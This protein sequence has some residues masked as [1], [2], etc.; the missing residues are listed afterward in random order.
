[1]PTT[2][3]TVIDIFTQINAIPRCSKKEAQIARWLGAWADQHG[4]TSDSDAAGNLVIR[5]PA[6]PGFE[7]APVV[8]LQGHMDMV[9]EKTPESDHDFDRDPIL[10]LPVPPWVSECSRG[11]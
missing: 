4:F 11:R 1:M 8:V 7:Q 3:D 2:A 5:V 6:T 10:S 9:C